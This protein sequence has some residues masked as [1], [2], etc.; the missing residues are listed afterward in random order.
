[1][2]LVYLHFAFRCF[3]CRSPIALT[4]H[5]SSL[6]SST[7]TAHRKSRG[8]LVHVLRNG[9]V[10]SR[11]NN[12]SA[13][14]VHGNHQTH[15]CMLAAAS[16]SPSCSRTACAFCAQEHAVCRCAW[17]KACLGCHALPV[18]GFHELTWMTCCRA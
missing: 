1:V 13:L 7:T 4:S 15:L 16:A 8:L 9:V 2:K 12:S 5:I 6:D 17:R 18:T 14:N 11:L 3:N 10:C